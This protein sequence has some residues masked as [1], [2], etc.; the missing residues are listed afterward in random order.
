MAKSF[1]ILGA[2]E[3]VS[4]YSPGKIWLVNGMGTKTSMQKRR[5]IYEYF[6][7]QGYEFLTIVHPRA[8]VSASAQ[9]EPGAQIMA[10]TVLQPGVRVGTNVII[11]TRA[12]VDHD[13]RIAGHCH[14]AHESVLCG[15]VRLEENVHVG[16]GACIVER[17]RIGANSFVAAG[18][19][20]TF[21]GV[22]ARPK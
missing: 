7:S 13:C 14:V 6:I 9:L 12:C 5:A 11:N 1:K 21:M 22:P 16:A 19:V 10:G 20:A 3:Y 18:A 15:G 2:D 8:S 4:L 17:I